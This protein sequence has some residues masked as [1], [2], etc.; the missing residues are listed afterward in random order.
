MPRSGSSMQLTRAADYGVRVMIHL[1]AQPDGE[2]ALLPALARATSAPESFLSKVLQALCHA[3]FIASRRGQ[4]GGF[5]I[6]ASGRRAT[7]RA[8]VEAID[9]PIC[10]NVCLVS[11]AS[12]KRKSYCQ[13][14]P[15]WLKA[16]EAMLG[17][18]ETSTVADLA[19][20]TPV[21]RTSLAAPLQGTALVGQSS[22]TSTGAH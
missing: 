10:L 11:G 16:Q 8:V 22:R 19:Y 21:V 12:C 7:I 18:L 14:H 9:G 15:I 1:A 17:V 4:A 20:H 5:E 2:R 3:G 13:A 6:L